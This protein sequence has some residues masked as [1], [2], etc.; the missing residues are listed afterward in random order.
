MN[1]MTTDD[2]LTADTHLIQSFAN[3][4]ALKQDGA[5]TAIVA[6]EGAHVT[7]SE[8]NRMI[9]G[10]GGLW[11]VNVGHGR[12][13][14]IDA[15]TEQLKTLDYYSTFYNFTHPAAAALAEKVASLAPGRLNNVYFGNSGSVANDTAVRVLHHYNNLRGKPQKKHILSR[16]GA[17]HGSTHMAMALTT[18]QYAE[19]WGAV[20]GLVTHLRAPHK[21]REAPDLSDEDFLAELE[22]DM[23][24]AIHRIG[25]DNICAFFAEPIQGAG[26]V[27]TA[28]PG[29]HKRMHEITREHD[30]AY[31]ADEVVT[32]WGR[33]GHMFSSQDV[34]DYTPDI[35]TTAK[36][37]TS[38]YQPLS[39]TIISDE[40]HE[41]IS[42]P[43]AM[44]L[45]GMT[46][47]GH[48]AAA[49]AGLANIAILERENIPERVR[50]T[51]KRFESNLRGLIDMNMVGEVRGSHF[52]IGIEF[53][54]NKDTREEFAADAMIGLAVSR[55]C[56]ERGLIARALGNIL[57]L[58]P[59][60]IMDEP[61]IDDIGAILR[62]SIETVSDG[63]GI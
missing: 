1:K 57:I 55:A 25:A 14:I 48:P 38:G 9:D 45:H 19:G 4:H 52:M 43:D 21:Y 10:I 18:P 20:E 39:A 32:A 24:D 7:D 22:K 11:C 51:G 63:L 36:G 60:L 5:R 15:I 58:S 29:Y 37:L 28:P 30:I 12:P 41:V 8:G 59:T 3:L 6:A 53:V 46:Y 17:Y 54:K 13:E 23:L 62:E 40:I 34:Y 33:L 49:A 44:F 42:G 27:I 35:I 50:T 61:M 2:I 16:M 26:G 31:V 47:S 56:Q